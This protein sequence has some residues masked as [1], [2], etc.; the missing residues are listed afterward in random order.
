MIV[1]DIHPNRFLLEELLSEYECMLAANGD[2]MWELLKKTLP[3]L[4]LMDIGLPGEDG[5]RLAEKLQ[6]DER[7]K[8]IPVIFLTAHSSKREIIDG[9]RFGGYDY[10]VKP[11]DEAVLFERIQSVFNKK[12]MEKMGRR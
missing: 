4:I 9:V 3:D 6:R 7:L 12:K 2:Q 10:L 1:D 8:D 5:L 11:V